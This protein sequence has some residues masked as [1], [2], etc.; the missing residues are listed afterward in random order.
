M[1]HRGT[2]EA[3]PAPQSVGRAELVDLL[4][5]AILD[6]FTVPRHVVGPRH[7][8]SPIGE[9]IAPELRAAIIRLPA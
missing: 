6:A 4:A 9:L 5:E 8:L 3:G 7:L 1:L 2:E